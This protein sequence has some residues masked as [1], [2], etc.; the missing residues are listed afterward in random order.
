MA[1]ALALVA[2]LALVGSAVAQKPTNAPLAGSNYV[3]QGARRQ[4]ARAGGSV[5]SF[6]PAGAH[7]RLALGQGLRLGDIQYRCDGPVHPQAG[8]RSTSKLPGA[9]APACLRPL[10]SPCAYVARRAATPARH[11]SAA[12]P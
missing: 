1:K 9:G 8:P 6:W 11:R 4:Q 10:A 12:P 2:L 7:Q 3:S 5:P